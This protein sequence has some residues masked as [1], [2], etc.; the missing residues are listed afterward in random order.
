MSFDIYLLS[1]AIDLLRFDIDLLSF[2]IYLL[3]FAL[4]LLSFLNFCFCNLAC[5]IMA[6]P[7]SICNASKLGGLYCLNCRCSVGRG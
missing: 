2:A 4:D 6:G 7:K 3:S 5:A 1:F